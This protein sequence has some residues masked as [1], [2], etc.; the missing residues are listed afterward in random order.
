M[1]RIYVGLTYTKAQ[2]ASNTPV[3]AYIGSSRSAAKTA[4]ATPVDGA[5]ATKGTLLSNV[6]LQN[7]TVR[8]NP[9]GT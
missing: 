8:R 1:P 7:H 6:Y 2:I 4:V 9:A 5:T 3:A